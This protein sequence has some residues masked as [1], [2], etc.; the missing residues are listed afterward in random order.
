MS[1][2]LVYDLETD[3]TDPQ[4]ATPVLMG[5]KSSVDSS[6]QWTADIGE[7]TSIIQ[8]HKFIVGWNNE[9][10]DNE[11]MKRLGADFR[12]KINID[13]MK[14]LHGKGYGND[15]GRKSIVVAPSGAHLNQIL[16]SKK[17]ADCAVALES[18]LK[19][20]ND[21][22]AIYELFKKPWK[23]LTDDE[24]Q[25]A[26]KY[27][28][29]DVEITSYIYEYLED[30]FTFFKDGGV[31][32]D[33]VYREFMRPEWRDKKKHLTWSVAS[34]VYHVLCNLADLEP[35]FGN[36]ESIPYGG[37]FVALPTQETA[38]GDVYCLDYTSLYPHIM[39]MLNLYGRINTNK[40]Y[41]NVKMWKGK[42]ICETGGVYNASNLAPVSKVLQ[43][44]YKER[45]DRKKR[46]DASE[47]TIKIIINTIYGLLGN[48]AF[49]S[50]SDYV[51]AGDCTRIGRQWVNAARLHFAEHGYKIL[52]TDTDSVYLVDPFKNKQKLLEIKDKHIRDI[53]A[54]VPF[55]QDT[56]D[57]DIDDEIRYI[58]F[59]K[60][61]GDNFLKK[62]YLYV[63]K[64]GKLKIKGLPIVKSTST[65][66]GR[67]VFDKFIKPEIIHNNRH[68]FQLSQ[69]A[70]WIETELKKDIKMASV[71][72]KCKPAEEYAVNS[73]IQ[74]QIALKFG[75]GQY[76]MLKLKQPHEKGV[77]VQQNYIR[78][79]DSGNVRISMIDLDK[80]W[81][82]LG[83]F[84]ATEQKT[85]EAFW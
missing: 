43:Q 73:Q 22:P 74:K 17:L 42:G 24:R 40:T 37:G 49:K 11:I 59:F 77:G 85:L 54:R 58:A 80:T 38:E 69:I 72:Y 53:K 8:Q 33:G 55:P 15:L 16:H 82:E 63:T 83:H 51:A 79:E 61:A 60:G 1:R 34:L 65:A 26:L 84:I 64:A 76:N 66:L 23:S 21:D 78:V 4:K 75:E 41:S 28:E 52:Y 56:F 20:L 32:I 45:K 19:K 27:L 50:V 2:V 30:F 14:I 36:G 7:M 5:F 18:P 35:E 25:W 3:S 70:E 31:E 6:F 46:G 57:M 9:D 13:L 62:N 39:M 47:Y 44:L 67:H 12:G 48:P 10:Y 71:F 68:K 29:H 81:Q